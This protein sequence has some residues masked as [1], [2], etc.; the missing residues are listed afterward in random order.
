MEKIRREIFRLENMTIE[1]I[2]PK[3]EETRLSRSFEI[4][5]L[6]NQA[7]DEEEKVEEEEEEEDDANNIA[8]STC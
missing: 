1:E 5:L 4:Q 7:L 2:P 8:C 3:I 6:L